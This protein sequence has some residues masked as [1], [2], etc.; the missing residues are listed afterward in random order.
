MPTL[1]DKLRVESCFT[2]SN[3]MVKLNHKCLIPMPLL[4][5]KQNG[6]SDSINQHMSNR[7]YQMCISLT[8]TVI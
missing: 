6:K 4:S 1:K 3:R 5:D 8:N 2:K 7:I